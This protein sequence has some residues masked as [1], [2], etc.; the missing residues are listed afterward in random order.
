MTLFGKVLLGEMVLSKYRMII[1]N[2]HCLSLSP[3]FRVKDDLDYQ[4]I[5]FC[6]SHTNDFESIR[7]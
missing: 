1:W 7:N 5:C 4:K 6:V 2:F 3:F